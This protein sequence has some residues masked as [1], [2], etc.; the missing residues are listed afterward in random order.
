LDLGLHQFGDHF[1]LV[2]DLGLQAL[3]LAPQREAWIRLALEGRRAFLKELLLPAL[4]DHW[5]EVIL[6]TQIG[7]WHLLQEMAS[8]DGYLLL[9]AQTALLASGHRPLP[10]R[11]DY[12]ASGET[13][14][15]TGA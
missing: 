15:P 5:L 14:I 12:C 13:P 1:V 10:S 9:G 8:D 4:E 7:D 2:G 11:I 6:I 3:Y